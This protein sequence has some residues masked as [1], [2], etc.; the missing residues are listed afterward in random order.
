MAN[1]SAGFQRAVDRAKAE[2]VLRAAPGATGALRR[3]VDIATERVELAGAR[4]AVTFHLSQIELEPDAPPTLGVTVALDVE[5]TRSEADELW[6]DIDAAFGAYLDDLSEER[7]RT[8]LNL[9]I[10]FRVVSNADRLG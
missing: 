2:D 9:L 5:L 7:Q 8:T 3:L 6:R 4:P 1:G 10:G